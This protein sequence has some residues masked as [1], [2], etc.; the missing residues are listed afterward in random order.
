MKESNP[1]PLEMQLEL[2]L[3][4][5]CHIGIQRRLQLT[6]NVSCP[7][8]CLLLLPPKDCTFLRDKHFISYIKTSVKV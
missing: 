3:I 2:K 1:D 5:E 4:L 8:T 6:M 7:Q